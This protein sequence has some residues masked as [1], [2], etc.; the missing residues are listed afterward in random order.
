MMQFRNSPFISDYNK[1][2]TDQYLVELELFIRRGVE[3]QLIKNIDTQ[4]LIATILGL[5]NE[6]SR[7]YSPSE[8]IK[9]ID[10]ELLFGICWDAIKA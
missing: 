1:S 4:T 8:S 6:Y 3:E 7:I 9:N 10:K 2:I 5:L